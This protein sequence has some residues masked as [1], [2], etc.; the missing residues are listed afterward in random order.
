MD[1]GGGSGH[2]GIVVVPEQDVHF[3][4][5]ARSHGIDVGNGGHTVFHNICHWERCAAFGRDPVCVWLASSQHAEEAKDVE[6]RFVDAVG[7]QFAETGEGGLVFKLERPS[8]S[9]LD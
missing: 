8:D 9:A 1:L 2:V 5:V 3:P 6:H 4:A 7:G